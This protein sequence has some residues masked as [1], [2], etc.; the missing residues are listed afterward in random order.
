ML[1]LNAQ[2]AKGSTGHWYNQLEQVELNYIWSLIKTFSKYF[3]ET[4]P[5][6][7]CSSKIYDLPEGGAIPIAMAVYLSTLR[8]LCLSNTKYE[9]KYLILKKTA[10]EREKTPVLHFERLKLANKDQDQAKEGAEGPRS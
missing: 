1:Q 8:N 10:V 6:I 3:A 5:L 9:L 7:K 2:Q 4:V